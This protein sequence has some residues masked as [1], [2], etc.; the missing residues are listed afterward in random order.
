MGPWLAKPSPGQSLV[1]DGH[2]TQVGQS[3]VRKCLRGLLRKKLYARLRM[4]P[5][6]MFSLPIV[7]TKDKLQEDIFQ[8]WVLPPSEGAD[9]MWSSQEW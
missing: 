2:M 8:P 5:G 3:E 9:I 6:E 7:L 4:L 1:Q